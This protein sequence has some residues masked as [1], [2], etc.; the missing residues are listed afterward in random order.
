M[1]SAADLLEELQTLLTEPAHDLQT[2]DYIPELCTI[3]FPTQ[4]TA[5]RLERFLTNWKILTKDPW[6]LNTVTG[7]RIPFVIPPRQRRPRVT[8]TTNKQKTL[9]L[10]EP[11]RTL[12]SK[13]AVKEVEPHTKFVSTLFLVKKGKDTGEFRPVINLEVLNR[14]LVKE[15]FKMEGLYTARSLIATNDFMMKLDLKDVYYA[16][17]MHVD[18]RKYLG[19]DWTMGG[20]SALSIPS[21]LPS[22]H[23]PPA[24]VEEDGKGRALSCSLGGPEV[25]VVPSTP[26]LQ[27]TGHLP[28]SFRSVNPNGCIIEGLGG[29]LQW[30]CSK[31]ALD[32]TGGDPAHQPPRAESC[33]PF[34]SVLPERL[35]SS[36]TAYTSGDGQYHLGGI[37]QQTGRDTISITVPTRSGNLVSLAEHGLL[38]DSTTS[39][40]SAMAHEIV[41]LDLSSL[42]KKTESWEFT[43]LSHVKASRPGHPPWMI[44]LPSYPT[45][46]KI[47]VIKTLE[48]YLARSE[49]RRKATRLLISYVR[50][51]GAISTQTLSRWIQNSLQL[52]GV[53]QQFTVHSTRSS[54]NSSAASACL[55]LEE[56]MRAADWSSGKTFEQFYHKPSTRG[57]FA[58]TILNTLSS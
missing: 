33:S 36:T 45:N 25:V 10:R 39:T 50:P 21:V 29:N 49:T 20:S 47:C 1:Q 9:L 52:A 27:Q 41:K 48:A 56:I 15:K 11:I 40:R 55:P 13:G 35:A 31:G 26:Q 32:P 38:A 37:Y 57:D 19:S 54:S 22:R 5:C 43:L 42:S 16:I 6:T 12:I 23:P 51:S 8:S 30:N 4:I 53:S 34:S 17:L 28:P 24:G 3:P 18:S 44:Y 2:A 7:Y 46:S 58:C 14:F